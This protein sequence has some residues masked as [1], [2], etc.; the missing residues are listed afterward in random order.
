MKTYL[1]DAQGNKLAY[2]KTEGKGP[3][4]VFLGGFCSDMSG[5]KATFLED[6]CRAA[7]RAFLRFDYFGH[8]ASDGDVVNGT[9]GRW[10]SN[11]L[12]MIDELTT[13]PQI[14][15]GSSMGGWLMLL[16][17]LKRPE[18]IHALIGIAAAPDFTED[19]S[20]LSAT[21]RDM[22]EKTGVCY[23]PS[24]IEGQPYPISAELIAEAEQHFLLKNDIN[25]HCPIRLLQGMNDADVPWQKATRIAERVASKDVSITLIKDGDHRLSSPVQLHLLAQ[26]IES[27]I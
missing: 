3:G 7:G 16:A 6:H 22:L 1:T 9:L 10:L 15:I 13:G 25:I 14:L 23:L 18:R 12:Q 24:G 27:L 17:A 8:G 11:A 26:T 2:C 4:V 5:T 20:R 19:F 21:Q